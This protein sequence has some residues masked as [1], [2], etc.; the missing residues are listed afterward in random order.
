[1]TVE[2]H[3]EAAGTTVRWR[4]AGATWGPYSEWHEASIAPADSVDDATLIFE[5]SAPYRWVQ[6]V[7]GDQATVF[8]RLNGKVNG[9]GRTLGPDPNQHQAFFG[10][11]WGELCGLSGGACESYGIEECS[12]PFCR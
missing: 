5:D 8:T 4:T 7:S 3:S 10:R 12:G 11:G 1:M 9:A 2:T 6:Y